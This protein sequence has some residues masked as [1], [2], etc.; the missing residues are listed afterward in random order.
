M[1]NTLPLLH[2]LEIPERRVSFL[3][4]KAKGRKNL[5]NKYVE[6][7]T[8]RVVLFNADAEA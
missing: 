5:S 4:G 3:A 6:P 2:S 7:T 8:G 1:S